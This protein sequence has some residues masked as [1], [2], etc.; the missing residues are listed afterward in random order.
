MKPQWHTGDWSD[1]HTEMLRQ[2][3]EDAQYYRSLTNEE[4]AW[5]LSLETTD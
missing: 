5:L 3:L 1:W 4:L 2:E